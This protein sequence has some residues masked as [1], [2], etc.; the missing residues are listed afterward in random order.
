MTSAMLLPYLAL[1]AV[2]QDYEAIFNLGQPLGGR[3]DA[4][5]VVAKRK[6]LRSSTIAR[7]EVSCCTASANLLS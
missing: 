3:L 4:L 1:E 7:A 2:K 5:R 6:S